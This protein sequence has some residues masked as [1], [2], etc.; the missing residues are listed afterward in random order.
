MKV[1]KLEQQENRRNV[2]ITECF[3]LSESVLIENEIKLLDKGLNSIPT[4]KKLNR[5]QTKNDLEKLG[6]D[7]KLR[8]FYQNDLS[9]SFSE[10]P[11]FKVTSSWTPPIRDLELELY[12][13]EIEDKL[14]NI[15]ESGKTYP[16]LSKDEREALKSL[17][18]NTEIIIKPADK[19][20]GVVIWSKHYYLLEALNQLTETNVYC[21][22]NSNTL[23]KVNGEIK[24]V[25]RNMFNLKEIDQKS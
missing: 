21:K 1:L 20:S 12:L 9:P 25:L 5:L 3:S 13:S 11:A 18:N 8:M 22:S 10:K 7:I 2:S 6:R 4:T 16:N 24:S 15:N 17:M 23:Q 14:I 19:V